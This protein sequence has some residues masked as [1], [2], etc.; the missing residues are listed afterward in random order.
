ML[1]KIG[2]LFVLMLSFFNSS[3]FAEEKN[4]VV[5]KSAVASSE[6]AIETAENNDTSYI[7]PRVSDVYFKNP[8]FKTRLN[9]MLKTAM[10]N[11]LSSK[12]VITIF[13]IE[14]YNQPEGDKDLNLKQIQTYQT[15]LLP[16]KLDVIHSSHDNMIVRAIL[17]DSSQ[18]FSSQNDVV[19]N[20][21]FLMPTSY[22][23]ALA[24]MHHVVFSEI[25]SNMIPFAMFANDDN[26]SSVLPMFLHGMKKQETVKFDSFS[27][28]TPRQVEYFKRA[29]HYNKYID[30]VRAHLNSDNDI[31]DPGAPASDDSSYMQKSRK[32]LFYTGD[33]IHDLYTKYD[34]EDADTVPVIVSMSSPIAANSVFET[35]NVTVIENDGEV[36]TIVGIFRIGMA[37]N[38]YKCLKLIQLPTDAEIEEAWDGSENENIS[39]AKKII[40]EMKD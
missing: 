23:D 32:R 35:R 14:N 34:Y 18:K 40:A 2:F 30:S 7:L 25:G 10:T 24:L 15:D 33:N 21:V 29:D 27:L 11:N 8:L 9:E 17:A 16:I 28:L 20:G 19:Y 4:G 38:I 12:K 37:Q 39:R 6:T 1:V 22:Y 31:D 36:K 5:L 13:K 3:A 26:L